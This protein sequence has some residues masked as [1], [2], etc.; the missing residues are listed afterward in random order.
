[1]KT[2][3]AIGGWKEGSLKYSIMTSTKES[4]IAFVESALRF[5][6]YYGF[7]GIDIDWEYPAHRGGIPEDKENF[8]LLLQEL[9]ERLKTWDLM[10]TVAVPMNTKITELA[11]DIPKVRSIVDYVFLMAYDF[12]DSTSKT[13]GL[14]A[15]MSEIK[16]TVNKWIENASD[17]EKRK[18]VLGVP[19]YARTF[20][21]KDQDIHGLNAAT[22][23][24]G[25]AG[26]FTNEA[27][28]LSY[29]EV[30]Y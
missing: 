26:E 16:N 8:V 25:V 1:M 22:Y 3:L 17:A 15:P 23:G 24:M 20:N 12:T 11:Y 6:V 14:L 4:R 2:L 29:Y 13:T 10:L 18:I 21:L 27:G 9:Q 30:E 19:T 7:D 28:F 5:V